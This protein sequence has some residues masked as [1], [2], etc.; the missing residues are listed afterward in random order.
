M[1]VV[2]FS[3]M[4]H[5]ETLLP[6]PTIDDRIQRLVSVVKFY[7]SGWHIKTPYA[8]PPRPRLPKPQ[9]NFTNPQPSHIIAVS[10]SLQTQSLAS[11]SLATGNTQITHEASIFPSKLPITQAYVT[12]VTDEAEVF[13]QEASNAATPYFLIYVQDKHNG[14][15]LY[16]AIRGINRLLFLPDPAEFGNADT[17][18][19]LRQ[20]PLATDRSS[21][22]SVSRPDPLDKSRL[23]LPTARSRSAPK[24]SRKLQLPSFDSLGIAVPRPDRP[25][26]RGGGQLAKDIWDR[27]MLAANN[28]HTPACDS[29]GSGYSGFDLSNGGLNAFG[30]EQ[31]PQG[32]LGCSLL[33]TPPDENG[34][35]DWGMSPQ[36]LDGTAASSPSMDLDNESKHSKLL[37]ASTPTSDSGMDSSGPDSTSFKSSNATERNNDGSRTNSYGSHTVHED[38]SGDGKLN[39]A[40]EVLLSK[41]LPC[42]TITEAVRIPSYTLPRPCFGS[43]NSPSAAATVSSRPQTT[44]QINSIHEEEPAPISTA[45]TFITDVV[46]EKFNQRGREHTFT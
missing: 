12:E 34:V 37:L 30:A 22:V 15:D 21:S 43:G 28:L 39:S 35:V 4:Q 14:A 2:S 40:V 32:R 36:S 44:N 31:Y 45:L 41:S 10:K 20:I 18:N 5:P 46:Q 26:L 3:F 13:E 16:V 6:M 23:S 27:S 7:R 8:R 24:I 25:R 9:S 33:L 19:L 11:D 38:G 17:E 1:P 29:L 42:S